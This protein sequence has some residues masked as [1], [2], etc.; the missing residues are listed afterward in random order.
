M[1]RLKKTGAG[2]A[3][4]MSSLNQLQKLVVTALTNEIEQGIQVGEVN[5]ATL[6]NALQLLR[7]NSV[8][9]TEDVENEFERLHMLLPR[10]DTE[11]VAKVC[12]RYE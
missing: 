9:A 11:A 12:T 7:D 4:S 10:I 1:P 6:R 3:A 8:T 2:D 5:Q